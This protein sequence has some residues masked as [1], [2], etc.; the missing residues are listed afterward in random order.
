MDQGSVYVYDLDGTNETKITASDG[1]A[2]DR[3][4]YSVAIGN[5]KIVVGAY[6]DDNSD[7]GAVYVYNL[8]GTGQTK[9]TAS[10]GSTQDAFGASVAIGNN[11]IAV[12]APD[13]TTDTGC[14]I[15][16]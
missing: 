4:G 15:C 1:A 2:D 5:N 14:S 10:D 13:I 12:G 6:G 16:L 7:T 8:D 3:F 9:I 11:K